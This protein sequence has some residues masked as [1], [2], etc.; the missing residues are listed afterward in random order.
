MNKYIPLLLLLCF[1]LSCKTAQKA[2]EPKVEPKIN[3]AITKSQLF[4][5]IDK[6]KFDFDW[7]SFKADIDYKGK[8]MNISVGS[9]FRIRKDSVIWM[10]VK[11]FGFEVARVKV[12]TDSI[13]AIDY[14]HGEYMVKDLKYLETKFNLPADFKVLQNILVG[15]VVYLTKKDKYQVKSIQTGYTIKDSISALQ[16]ICEVDAQ[17]YR[18]NFMHFE[19][20]AKNRVV[21]TNYED[22]QSFSD[23]GIFSYLRTFDIFSSETGKINIKIEIDKNLEVNV[24]KAIKFEIPSD[25]RKVDR[26]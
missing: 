26:F 24:P 17:H 2:I 15:N 12:T 20:V 21:K 5:A 16:S 9:N 7:L 18:P 11:K 10:N 22:Y 4:E 14:F 13:Y 19:E 8:P 3:T 6:S 25:Y 1:M 23:Y